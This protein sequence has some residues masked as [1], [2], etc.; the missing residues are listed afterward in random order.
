MTAVSLNSS[1]LTFIISCDRLNN[2]TTT[3]DFSPQG[4]PRRVDAEPRAT[5]V[6]VIIHEDCEA[7]KATPPKIHL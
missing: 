3:D 2:I 5:G 4:G 1:K 7:A 6:Y